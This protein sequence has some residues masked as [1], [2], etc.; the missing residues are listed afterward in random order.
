MSLDPKLNSPAILVDS[1]SAVGDTL[2]RTHSQGHTQRS[3]ENDVTGCLL[4][5]TVIDLEGLVTTFPL[6]TTRVMM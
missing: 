6:T 4:V 3:T 1:V 2:T 5:N